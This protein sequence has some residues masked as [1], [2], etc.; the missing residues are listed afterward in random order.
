MWWTD[1]PKADDKL[2]RRFGNGSGMVRERFANGSQ[3][4][5]QMV[6]VMFGGGQGSGVGRVW[7]GCG[8][9]VSTHHEHTTSHQ[10]TISI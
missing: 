2:G 1:M 8:T 7:F 3:S 9:G 5:S 10:E 6:R 4:V